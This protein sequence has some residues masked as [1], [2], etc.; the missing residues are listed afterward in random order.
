MKE[1][2]S[3]FLGIQTQQLI[4][5]VQDLDVNSNEASHATTYGMCQ[6]PRV[7]VHLQLH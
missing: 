4:V 5:K 7:L 6:R 3:A 1:A 2:Q